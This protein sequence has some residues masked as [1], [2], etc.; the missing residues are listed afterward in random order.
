MVKNVDVAMR[1]LLTNIKHD[2]VP[3]E[4]GGHPATDVPYEY[5]IA[6]ALNRGWIERIDAGRYGLTESEV[7]ALAGMS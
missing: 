7:I 4:S 3:Y 2:R 1:Q 5:D 6:A